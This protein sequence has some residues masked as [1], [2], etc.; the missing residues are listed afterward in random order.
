M[1]IEEMSW[2]PGLPDE[3][4]Y[5]QADR[6]NKQTRPDNYEKPNIDLFICDADH[7]GEVI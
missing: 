2:M 4:E 1:I 7:G 6:R 5:I 3:Q